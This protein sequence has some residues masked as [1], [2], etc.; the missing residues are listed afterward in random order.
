MPVDRGRHLAEQA[1]RRHQQTLDRTHQTL[2]EMA[3]TGEP[4]TMARV[5][6][7]AGV[8]RSWLYSQPE[9]RDRIQQLRGG[10]ASADAVRDTVT[11]ASDDSLRQRLTLAHERISRLREENRQLRD[12]LAHAHGQLRAARLHAEGQ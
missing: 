5:A 10:R 4:V 6:R 9:I 11:R 7:R 1:Q 2:T 8:S 3:D 12:A